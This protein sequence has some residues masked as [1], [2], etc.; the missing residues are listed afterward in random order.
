M[1]FD[2]C[3][4]STAENLLSSPILD[5]C[6][7]YLLQIWQSDFSLSR[8]FTCIEADLLLLLVLTYLK[9]SANQ[10]NHS[11]VLLEQL[12]EISRIDSVFKLSLYGFDG[13]KGQ[14]KVAVEKSKDAMNKKTIEKI[15]TL[16]N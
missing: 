9:L 1:K 7:A 4:E 15:V 2:S 5:E 14:L 3:S 11:I 10:D 13:V 16:L 6:E 12:L 8:C